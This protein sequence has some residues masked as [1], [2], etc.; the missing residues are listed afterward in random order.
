M[1]T[2]NKAILLGHVGKAPEV[3]TTGG[4]TI[5]A[6][7]SIATSDRHKDA[8]GNWQDDTQWHDLVAFGRT[9]E[10]VRDYVLK[11]SKLYVEGRI[12]TR[13]WEK[14]GQKHY[15]TEIVANELVLL[16]GKRDAAPQSAEVGDEDIPF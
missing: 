15:R 3:K 8:Q 9:A 2:V 1:K 6:N 5:V 4:G 13:T 14:D 16:D 11:G 12:H 10:I 7:F